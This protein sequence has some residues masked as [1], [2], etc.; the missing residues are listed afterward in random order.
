MQT[1]ADITVYNAVY[2]N[3]KG[4]TSYKRTVIQ[5]VHWFGQVVSSVSTG[6]L[7]SA[8][9]YTIRV[10]GTATADYLKTYVNPTAWSKL[11]DQE[12]LQHYTFADGD[13]IVRGA[14]DFEVTGLKGFTWAD[15]EKKFDEVATVIGRND[16]RSGGLSHIKV[17]GK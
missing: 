2:D 10:P 4:L 3:L 13:K 6:G 5:G 9:S 8:N 15:I 7:N 16:N 1:N 11:T 14:T 17:V 12:K